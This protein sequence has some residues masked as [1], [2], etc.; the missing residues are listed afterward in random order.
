MSDSDVSDVSQARSFIIAREKTG[1]FERPT[2]SD[3]LNLYPSPIKLMTN[4]QDLSN[5][6]ELFINGPL[7][8]YSLLFTQ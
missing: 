8:L 2:F 1:R 4:C 3:G 7:S 5:L 6:L